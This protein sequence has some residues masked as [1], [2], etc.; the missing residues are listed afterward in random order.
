MTEVFFQTFNY[1]YLYATTFLLLS[2]FGLVC[3]RVIKAI[4]EILGIKDLY[5]KVEGPTCNYQCLTRAFFIGL[6]SQV[7]SYKLM[8]I[9]W[10]KPIKFTQ[11]FFIYG[12]ASILY[13]I[14][15]LKRACKSCFVGNAQK[16]NL[17]KCF[18][19]NIDERLHQILGSCPWLTSHMAGPYW[20]CT[21]HRSFIAFTVIV[22][23]GMLKIHTN[24][25]WVLYT[26]ICCF[27]LFTIGNAS[28]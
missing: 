12:I 25:H 24:T 16:K 26:Y 20:I 4:C 3:H 14:L 2:G 17:L 11:W 9:L 19:K 27:C 21:I 6:M 18:Q 28:Q 22:C 5:A 13:D 7:S 1:L 23:R 10:T 15:T 8:T